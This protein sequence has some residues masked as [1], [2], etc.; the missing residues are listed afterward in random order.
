MY[1]LPRLITGQQNP[2]VRFVLV[3]AFL[4]GSRP[5]P[6]PERELSALQENDEAQSKRQTSRDYEQMPNEEFN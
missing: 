5:C 3:V 6:A 4:H 1:L 2:L